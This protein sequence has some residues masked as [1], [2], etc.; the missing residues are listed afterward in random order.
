MHVQA[1]GRQGAV[2]VLRGG[3]RQEW[4]GALGSEDWGAWV[5]WGRQGGTSGHRTLGAYSVRD[6][7]ESY[8]ACPCVAFGCI[9]TIAASSHRRRSCDGT[10]L[11]CRFLTNVITLIRRYSSE[12]HLPTEQ[13]QQHAKPRPPLVGTHTGPA[14]PFTI[15]YIRGDLY[16]T[17]LRVTL[18]YNLYVRYRT[19]FCGDGDASLMQ[20]HPRAALRLG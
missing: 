9:V 3:T 17:Q 4:A 5:N 15:N 13:E 18:C 11:S 2:T 14:R 12:C 6:P 10:V 8:V 7:Y 1:T 19:I 20:A 16:G